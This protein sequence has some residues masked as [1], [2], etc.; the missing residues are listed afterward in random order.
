M[1]A[2]NPPPQPKLPKSFAKDREIRIWSEQ[3]GRILLQLWTRTGGA[4]DII[5]DAESDFS[6][7]NVAALFDLNKRIGS[8]MNLTIDTSGFTV[9]ISEQTT[10]QTEA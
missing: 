1:T 3:I 4:T 6:A 10:D 2:V 9:D 8:G 7:F 5:S